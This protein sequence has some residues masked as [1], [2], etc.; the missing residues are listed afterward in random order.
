MSNPFDYNWSRDYARLLKLIT[1]EKVICTFTV[2]AAFNQ[3]HLELDGS[4]LVLV[5]ARYSWRDVVIPDGARLD[6]ARFSAMC[7]FYDLQYLIP[8]SFY[9]AYHRA[10]SDAA[11]FVTHRMPKGIDRDDAMTALNLLNDSLIT[12]E[13]E[14]GEDAR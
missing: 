11:E 10:L 14:F 2:D 8:C 4:N 6:E 7:N 5:N 3:G 13:L 12:F 1:H 9:Q